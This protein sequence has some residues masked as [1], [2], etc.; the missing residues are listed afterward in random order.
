MD[1]I[2]KQLKEK[3]LA[4]KS[5]GFDEALALHRSG[6]ERPYALIAAASEIR[7][8]FKGKRISLCA[9]INA[10]SGRCPED[11]KF[12]GQSVHYEGDAP[13][14]GLVSREEIVSRAGR[15]K[16][17]G[18]RMFGIVTSGTRIDAE[19][20]W[21]E[22]YG[23][24]REIRA[25]G[26]KPCVSLGLLT[27]ERAKALK[28]A[29]LYR[30]HHNLETARSFFG[31]ICTTHDYEEDIDTILAAREAGLKTCCGG[32]IGMGESIEQRVE[33]ALTLREL[34]VDS[35]P[36]NI[37]NPR[38]G[39]PL[40]KTGRIHPLELLVTISVFRFLLPGKDIKLCG[41]KEANLR[42]L[43]PLGIVAGAN[44]LMIGGYL[45]TGG[46]RPSSTWRC[47]KT[48]GC[49][50]SWK[51]TKTGKRSWRASRKYNPTCQ[52]ASILFIK[53]PETVDSAVTIM[54]YL[55]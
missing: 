28:A 12:C 41:G 32:I 38:P 48:S 47:C 26:I 33:F 1:G 40:M 34:D 54:P 25:A 35:V 20:E 37:L 36:F 49:K 3:A 13:V 2:L 39:T 6:M 23:A 43:L 11:C 18:A 44:S 52:G 29:G 22:I 7:E 10:K 42:Q 27:R 46:K 16:D 30:Y 55:T 15:M 24:V 17:E 45:T 53:Q 50:P 5:I 31:S 8:T 14:Y 51:K 9:I 19:E 21:E 4:G